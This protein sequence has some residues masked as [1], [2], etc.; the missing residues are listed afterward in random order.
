M[1]AEQLL[2]YRECRYG[3]SPKRSGNASTPGLKDILE[4]WSY[5]KKDN[6][7]ETVVDENESQEFRKMPPQTMGLTNTTPQTTT[8]E[9]AAVA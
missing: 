6:G 5:P 2:Q 9:P 3:I 8:H 4:W 1:P 7:L